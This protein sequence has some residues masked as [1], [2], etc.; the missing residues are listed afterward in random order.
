MQHELVVRV[1]N[2]LME[3]VCV[4]D[5]HSYFNDAK[6]KIIDGIRYQEKDGLRAV[7]SKAA[8]ATFL[9]TSTYMQYST[10]RVH[11]DD[12]GVCVDQPQFQP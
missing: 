7:L 1:A 10:E 12:R 5:E 9:T 8:Q 11:P 2:I 6:T 3:N 4:Y